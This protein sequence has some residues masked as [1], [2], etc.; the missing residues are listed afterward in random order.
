MTDWKHACRRRIAAAFCVAAACA[1][2]AG[3]AAFAQGNGQTGG[4]EQ[5]AQ[6]HPQAQK[7]QVGAGTTNATTTGTS[8]PMKIGSDSSSGQPSPPQPSLCKDYKG[9]VHKQCLETVLRGNGNDASGQADAGSGKQ[10]A[11]ARVKRSASG[12]D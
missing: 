9:K 8:H 11:S 3:S 12:E 7:A 10:P 2:L 6:A 4:Q 1:A 5:Q